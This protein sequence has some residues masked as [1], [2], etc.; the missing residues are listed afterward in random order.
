M[1]DNGLTEVESRRYPNA[2]I[3]DKIVGQDTNDGVWSLPYGVSGAKYI[4]S[5]NVYSFDTIKITAQAKMNGQMWYAF[6]VDGKHIGWIHD[7]A[8]DNGRT[9]KSV[10]FKVVKIRNSNHHAIWTKPYGLAY[11][12]YVAPTRQYAYEK[13]LV[14]KTV[15]IEGTEWGQVE[16]ENGVI[17][18][19]DLKKA[20][21]NYAYPKPVGNG[22][23]SVKGNL[24]SSH[25]IWTQPY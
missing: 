2:S 10:S 19:I 23:A 11:S 12:K 4:A 9:V 18:W 1:F 5:S 22:A 21:E 25:S 3:N 24:K 15:T 7:K 14:N 17:R 6:S 16:N 8:L 13:V 20:T